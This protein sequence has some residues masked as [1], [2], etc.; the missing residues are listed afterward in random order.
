MMM[1]TFVSHPGTNSNQGVKIATILSDVIIMVQIVGFQGDRNVKMF[2][3]DM[4]DI[5]AIAY[6]LVIIETN[7]S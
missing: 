5:I 4:I 2:F 1:L 3:I 7:S 6:S